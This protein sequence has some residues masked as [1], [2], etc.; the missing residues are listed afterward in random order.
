METIKKIS[1]TV[2][3]VTKVRCI[4]KDVLLRQK[5]ILLASKLDTETKLTEVNKRL[6]ALK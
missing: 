6:D 2:L 4:D 5:E 3:E 1:D